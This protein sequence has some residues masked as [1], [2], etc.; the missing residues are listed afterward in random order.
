MACPEGIEPTTSTS[1]A[2]AQSPQPRDSL[3]PAAQDGACDIKRTRCAPECINLSSECW[4][5]SQIISKG[6][7]RP[8]EIPENHENIVESPSDME[9][10]IEEVLWCNYIFVEEIEEDEGQEPPCSTV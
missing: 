8:R 7:Q 2:G 4:A 1:D 10:D 3:S 9:N 6:L 5:K